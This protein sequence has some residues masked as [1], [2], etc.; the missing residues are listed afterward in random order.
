MTARCPEPACPVRYA[1][2][3]DRRCS[4][5][6]DTGEGVADRLARL[7]TLTAAPGDGEP[8]PLNSRDW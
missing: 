2:G 4:D 1:T 3:D 7:T 8:I 6:T 5:H